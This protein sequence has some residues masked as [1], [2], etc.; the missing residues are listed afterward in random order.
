MALAGLVWPSA[1]GV[2]EGLR[3]LPDASA[4]A[5]PARAIGRLAGLCGDD[6]PLSLQL[7]ADQLMRDRYHL[8]QHPVAVLPRRLRWTE[9]PFG[10]R[11]WR[12][13]LQMLRYVN[14]LAFAWEETG[15]VRYRSRARSLVE[16]WLRANLYA[17]PASN[18]AW[19]SQVA[20]WRT[21]TLIC[22]TDMFP[23][24]WLTRA[25]A[26]HGE[27]LYRPGTWVRKGN[28]ALNQAIALLDAGCHLRRAAWR[29][30]AAQRIGILARQEVDR[31]G[32]SAEQATKYDLYDYER[33]SVA[34]ALLKA[35]RVPRPEGLGRIALIPR[36]LAHATRPDGHLE[37]IGDTDDVPLAPIPGTATEFIPSGCTVGRHPDRTVALY[38]AGYAFIRTGWG[39][40]RRCREETFVSLR[41]QRGH[42]S[43]GHDDSGGITLYGKGGKL[44]VDPGYGDQNS[45]RWH[46]FFVSR[47]AHNVVRVNGMAARPDRGSVLTRRIVTPDTVDL[48]VRIRV[49]PGVTL[50]RRVIV[51]RQLGYVVV[52][53][54][55]H[56]TRPLRYEQLWHLRP[57]A[58]PTIDGRR[59]WTR[60]GN[61]DLLIRQ[62]LAGGTTRRVAGSTSPIQGWF[63]RSYG[64][65]AKAPVIIQSVSGRSARLVT[66]LVP[67]R[68]P[69]TGGRPPVAVRDVRV[70][71]N[72]FRFVVSV[73]G[74]RERLVATASG[75]TVSR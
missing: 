7:T 62:L 65:R 33:F 31:K 42:R 27:I 69:N 9:D 23:G 5:A 32:V 39:E 56:S 36:F 41:F 75:V 26:R 43:H 47:A 40:A 73:E 54:T 58:R 44:L 2:G 1:V 15:D 51:S 17:G 55:M 3:R 35:C 25:I 66:L 49:Y 63:S 60:S 28:H 48:R 4:S 45:S 38:R 68:A 57:G 6:S 13:K 8:G 14:A 64:H 46:Q 50:L 18:A 12:Q 74:R 24:D 30:R 16:S 21:M 22:L 67:F 10:D 61:G 71:P 59:T 53:D 70:T 52:E 20:A 34:I 11:Q 72:G 29:R 19:R 37:T